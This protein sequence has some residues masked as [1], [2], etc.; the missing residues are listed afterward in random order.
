MVN[1]G[2]PSKACALCRQRKI[3]CDQ[4]KPACTQCRRLRA[5]CPGYRDE[6]DL[7]FKDDSATAARKSLRNRNP[8]NG[9]TSAVSQSLTVPDDVP[10]APFGMKPPPLRILNSSLEELATPFF[11]NYFFGPGGGPMSRL[12]IPSLS[13]AASTKIQDDPM[14]AAVAAV[15]SAT[16]ANM[17]NSQQELMRARGMYGTAVQLT[18]EAV[19]Q[20]S[21]FS[22]FNL[23]LTVLLLSYFEVGCGLPRS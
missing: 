11:F 1:Y 3:K 19:Q 8:P 16:L 18:S 2:K 7:K 6:L 15:G 22:P 20:G 21:G 13:R 23:L 17:H 12:L 5:S 10:K 9:A 4:I 14:S